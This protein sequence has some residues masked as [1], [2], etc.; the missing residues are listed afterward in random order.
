VVNRAGV[1]KENANNFLDALSVG[2]IKNKGGG[3]GV[4]ILDTGTVLGFLPCVR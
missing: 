2:G 1:E 4:R 3:V